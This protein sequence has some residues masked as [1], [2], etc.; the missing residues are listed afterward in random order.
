VVMALAGSPLGWTA[1]TRRVAVVPAALQSLL[2]RLEK[3]Q[4]PRLFYLAGGTGLAL[5]L[6][7][8]RSVDLDF[9]S[10]TNRL[11]FERR[12]TLLRELRR[13][14]GWTLLKAEDGTLQGRVGRVRIS[15]FWYPQPLVKPLVGRGRIRIA[16]LEDIGLM[17]LGAVIGRGA[18]K[19]FV[20]IYAICQRIPLARLLALSRKKFS[21]AHDFTLQ[22]L[23]ALVFFEDAERDPSLM[24][25]SPVAWET[26]KTFLTHEVRAL[27]HRYLKGLPVHDH[28]V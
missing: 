6:G 18:R 20:D 7:H 19:D 24:T 17:K 12:R 14:P 15:L 26:V 27:T 8:R 25:A 28:P 13:L 3:T 16:S 10:T 11:D 4:I 22:A 23:K 5:L 1:M 2:N 21:D 9:F